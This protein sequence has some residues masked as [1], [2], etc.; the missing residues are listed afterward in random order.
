MQVI[1]LAVE[2]RTETGKGA[3]RKLRRKG[4]CPAVLYRAGNEPVLFAFDPEELEFAIRK[5]GDRNS[6]FQIELDGDTRVCLIKEFQRH[7][8]S[9]RLRH[10]DFFEVLAD[11]AV[12]VKVRVEPLGRAEGTKLG[13]SLNVLRRTLDVRCLPAHIPASIQVDVT[14]LNVGDFVRVAEFQAP[15]NTT[16][17]FESNFNVI[18]C[19]GKRLE[20]EDLEDDEDEEGAEG[21]EAEAPAEA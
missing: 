8:V 7:P 6:L 20:L 12:V 4:M 1:K 5:R 11:Q 16:I 9:R 15:E 18:S 21:E 3:A 17:L 14:P 10:M 13:G 2:P 19:V